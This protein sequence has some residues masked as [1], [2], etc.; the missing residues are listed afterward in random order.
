LENDVPINQ[1]NDSFVN[2][3]YR[4]IADEI[5]FDTWGYT[6]YGSANKTDKSIVS[7]AGEVRI[8]IKKTKSIIS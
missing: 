1:I 4:L 6:A 7:D 2:P 5:S 8:K 3:Y